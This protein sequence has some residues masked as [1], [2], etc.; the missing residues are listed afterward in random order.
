MPTDAVNLNGVW[1][2][3]DPPS[4]IDNVSAIIFD[5][6]A[7]PYSAGMTVACPQGDSGGVLTSPPGDMTDT[8]WDGRGPTSAQLLADGVGNAVVAR[9]NDTGFGTT[10]KST[11][12]SRYFTTNL[13]GR[14]QSGSVEPTGS[15]ADGHVGWVELG[16]NSYKG[17]WTQLTTY[18]VGDRINASGFVWRCTADGVSNNNANEPAWPPA[19]NGAV[20]SV[21][22]GTAG[23]GSG[24][25]LWVRQGTYQGAWAATTTYGAN[26]YNNL[27]GNPTVVIAD[28]VSLPGTPAKVLLFSYVDST[29][30]GVTT[31]EPG[32]SAAANQTYFLDGD[33]LFTAGS[34][35]F[36][37]NSTVNGSEQ[38]VLTGVKAPLQDGKTLRIGNSGVGNMQVVL[39]D[40][41]HLTDINH[42]A[43]FTRV[44]VDAA[45]DPCNSFGFGG[46]YKS[47]YIRADQYVLLQYS[48]HDCQWHWANAGRMVQ[49]GHLAGRGAGW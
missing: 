28:C 4:G 42:F 43:P 17:G 48:V 1:K 31:S 32:W 40:N 47:V 26:V 25:F 3:Y 21:S 37:G 30:F 39:A 27:S 8:I 11:T 49:G 6:T 12:G 16:T 38:L 18:A 29:I 19:S 10:V 5:P 14:G 35:G 2:N 41:A 9:T 36:P 13:K 46:L 15:Q 7:V 34:T 20:M 24:D 33:V 44:Q 22:D 45:S 23:G